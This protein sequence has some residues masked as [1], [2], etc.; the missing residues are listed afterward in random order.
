[1]NVKLVWVGA[2]GGASIYNLVTDIS[3]KIK[4][5]SHNNDCKPLYTRGYDSELS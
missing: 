5:R 3:L 1:M 2:C 4:Y